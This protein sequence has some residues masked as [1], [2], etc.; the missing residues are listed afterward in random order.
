MSKINIDNTKESIKTI[1]EFLIDLIGA[2]IPGIIFLFSAIVSL[3][4][5]ALILIFN[6]PANSNEGES[7]KKIDLLISNVFQGWFWLVIFFTFLILAYAIGNIFYRLDIKKIDRKSFK[8]EKKRCFCNDIKPIIHSILGKYEKRE[9]DKTK[10]PDKER[11][12]NRFINKYCFLLEDHLSKNDRYLLD[13]KK[14]SL[15]EELTEKKKVE[16]TKAEAEKMNAEEMQAEE[17]QNEETQSKDIRLIKCLNEIAYF[18]YNNKDKNVFGEN[19]EL[20]DLQNVNERTEESNK[21]ITKLLTP[22]MKK[23]SIKKEL[24]NKNRCEKLYAIGWY[25][26]FLLRSENACDNEQDC[27]FPYEYYN[28]YLIKRKET[29]LLEYAEHWCKNEK[30]RSKNALNRLKLKLQLIAGQDYSILVKNEAHIRMSSSSWYVAGQNMW[31]SG[32]FSVLLLGY[33]Y[34]QNLNL[35]IVILFPILMLLLN[36]FIH[37]SIIKYLHYQ[38]LREIFFVLQVFDEYFGKDCI[39]RSQD[40]QEN[41]ANCYKRKNDINLLEKLHE[42]QKKNN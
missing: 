34:L 22:Y 21:I 2:L 23:N 41:V 12:L 27:Q 31:I 4:L 30:S 15:Y 33:I 7:V 19:N 39:Y 1:N 6:P 35:W 32:V 14:K 37:R 26:L 42:L 25:F 8:Y 36:W 20:K 5:P 24:N 13:D 18:V 3:I 10:I 9:Q 11:D 17:M 16:K 38:R 40:T 28:T 29:H